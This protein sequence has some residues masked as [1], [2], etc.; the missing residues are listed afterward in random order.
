[1]METRRSDGE[2]RQG[3]EDWTDDRFVAQWLDRQGGRTD[4]RMGQF[5]LIRSLVPRPPEER[6][7]YLDVG[8]GDGWLDE[9]IL[10]RFTRAE[11]TLVDG[12]PLMGERARQR[13]GQFGDRVRVV[14]GDLS[15]PSWAEA[16]DGPF[17]L[18]VSSIAIHN[19][20]DPVRIRTLYAEIFQLMG[21]GGFFM[22]LDY[23]RPV[24]PA[25]RGMV[26][27][28]GTDPDVRLLSSSTGGGS[29]GTLEE[30]LVWLREAGFA[31]VDCFCKEFQAALFGG[32]RGEISLP[33]PEGR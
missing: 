21:P 14:R 33:V 12:S 8:A 22:N 11:A 25:L 4:E 3:R 5:T 31:P 30:Q 27:V 15:S 32:F 18:A 29:S 26:R 6:F 2:P 1:M 24:S 7:R 28:A 16:V 23:V 17:D 10:T 13:L 9:V 20:R 19:L